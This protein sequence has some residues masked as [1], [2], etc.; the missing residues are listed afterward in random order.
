M[1]LSSRKRAFHSYAPISPPKRSRL[2]DS[3]DSYSSDSDSKESYRS[4]TRSHSPSS[5]GPSSSPS[6]T[7]TCSSPSSASSEE[8][9]HAE[10]SPT[11]LSSEDEEEEE[12]A[13]RY[14]PVITVNRPKPRIH[15]IPKSNLSSR[16]SAFLPALKA[17]NEDLERDIAAGRLIS[18]EINDDSES[19]EEDTTDE[20]RGMGPPYI[21]MNLGLGVL[22]ETGDDESATSSDESLSSSDGHDTERRRARSDMNILGNLMGNNSRTTKPT[23]EEI[24]DIS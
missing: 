3:A 23:I 20:E 12:E 7:S 11:F 1:P 16:L 2:D 8:D 21:E 6:S 9:G 18:A 15:H 13:E 14:E 24:G 19:G 5:P 22:Q 4:A 17:A 10:L